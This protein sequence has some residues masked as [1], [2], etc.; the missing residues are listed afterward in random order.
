MI[1]GLFNLFLKWIHVEGFFLDTD[2]ILIL[3]FAVYPKLVHGHYLL[4]LVLILY[5]SYSC[6]SAVLACTAVRCWCW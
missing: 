3:L 4:L 6:V 5:A 1:M 2:V